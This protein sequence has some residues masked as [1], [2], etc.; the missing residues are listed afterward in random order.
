MNITRTGDDF[1]VYGAT[2]DAELF[3]SHL[4]AP[5]KAKLGSMRQWAKKDGDVWIVRRAA[6]GALR[7]LLP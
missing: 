7:S 1:R 3:L 6:A 2:A 4:P 5:Q